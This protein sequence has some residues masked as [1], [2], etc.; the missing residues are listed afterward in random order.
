[1]EYVLNIPDK[2]NSDTFETSLDPSL[3]KGKGV[4]AAVS[5][6]DT[7]S[8]AEN[9]VSEIHSEPPQLFLI[10]K[11]RMSHD[12]CHFSS[13]VKRQR[14]EI[15]SRFEIE[16]DLLKSVIGHAI[17]CP[18]HKKSIFVLEAKGG[19]DKDP[20]SGHR[21][22]S[23]PIVD[24]IAESK[25]FGTAV[26]SFLEEEEN[27]PSSQENVDNMENMDQSQVGRNI[28]INEALRG[29][30][31]R[32]ACGLVIRVNPGTLSSGS[33]SKLD[34]MLVEFAASGI[35]IMSHPDVQR[36]MGAKDALCKI[37][38][39]K[40]GMEDTEVFYDAVSFANGFLK[41]IAYRPRVIK[42]NSG[43]QGE[44]IWICKLKSGNYCKN[45]GD[46]IAGLEEELILMEA[47]DNHVE[48]HT[49]SEFIEFCING[50]TEKSGT[51]ESTHPGRYFEGGIDAGSMLV[52]QR[53]L[54]RVVEGEVRCVMVGK[55]LVE[56]VHKKPREGGY[57]ATLKSGAVYSFYSAEEP[58]FANLVQQFQ[59]DLPAIMS[60]LGVN[61][62][63]LPLL[64][65][66]DFMYGDKDE[67]GKDTFYVGEFNCSCVG[68]T[69]QLHLA[70]TVGAIAV[71]N[72]L[73]ILKK[74]NID[75]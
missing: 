58:I 57:S 2:S 38:H 4:I 23:I 12:G 21:R 73:A 28:R 56:I 30:I 24:S 35:L 52:D 70:K 47:S 32:N 15:S 59:N 66:A 46:R 27:H 45:Y 3:T 36:R 8:Y 63:Q 34:A 72:C 40:C 10:D 7:D 55:K 60:S 65:A 39:L 68:I 17:P 18:Q 14:E 33:Q 53:F 31:F 71:E 67:D 26:L 19:T 9:S 37:K 62:L 43:S 54:P 20:I 51:W 61:N 50:H 29:Y 6:H 13:E 48:Y 49:A 42:Q 75:R 22:D 41:N 64:W 11:K 5:T 69:K 74:E 16:E 1:M 44:G 25:C